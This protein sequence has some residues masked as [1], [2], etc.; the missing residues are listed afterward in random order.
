MDKTGL[1]LLLL[2]ARVSGNKEEHRVAIIMYRVAGLPG[3]GGVASWYCRVAGRI[4]VCQGGAGR[5][6][7][8]ADRGRWPSGGRGIG[9]RATAKWIVLHSGA[10]PAVNTNPCGRGAGLRRHSRPQEAHR[11]SEGR[12]RYPEWAAAVRRG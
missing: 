5:D 2:N 6:I 3:G 1:L 11:L 4:E 7:L 12:S 10:G 8:F 9:G